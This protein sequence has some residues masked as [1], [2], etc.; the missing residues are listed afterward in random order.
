MS[1]ESVLSMPTYWCCPSSFWCCCSSCA[2]AANSGG[3]FVV[4]VERFAGTDPIQEAA[5]NAF[6]KTEN[7]E[8]G[9][10]KRE[11]TEKAYATTSSKQSWDERTAQCST[12]AALFRADICTL[13]AATNLF[14]QNFCKMH[15]RIEARQEPQAALPQ[16]QAA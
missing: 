12:A 10:D 15:V 8:E 13:R 3:L 16:R 7:D 9:E 14:N 11:R 2:P 6:E 4:A 5:R 1:V